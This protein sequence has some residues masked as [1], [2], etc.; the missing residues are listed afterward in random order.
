MSKEYRE[1]S[2]QADAEFERL[3]Y[4]ALKACGWLLP[5]TVEEVRRAETELEGHKV[6]LPETLRDP[7]RLLDRSIPRLGK[8]AR[9]KPQAETQPPGGAR[10]PAAL[11]D[12]ARELGLSLGG[13]IRIFELQSQVVA[14]RSSSKKDE[15]SRDDWRRFYEAVKEF[16]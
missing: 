11:L 8:S 2:I 7:F 9:A 12:L 15:L 10:L 6:E 3:V 1:D 4:Q 14:H 13:A 5:E 16:L